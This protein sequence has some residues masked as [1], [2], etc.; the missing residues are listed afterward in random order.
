MLGVRARTSGNTPVTL[1]NHVSC[2]RVTT[3][4]ALHVRVEVVWEAGKRDIAPMMGVM[5]AAIPPMWSS[6]REKRE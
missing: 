3:V 4:D 2:V 1:K 5:T 6:E